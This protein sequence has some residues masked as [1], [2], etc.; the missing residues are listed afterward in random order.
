MRV[1]IVST[2]RTPIGRAYSGA[3]NAT[4]APTL[5]THVIQKVVRDTCLDPNDVEEVILGC[6]RPEGTQGGNLARVAAMRSGLP[7]SVSG[8]TVSR[9]CGSGLQA[10]VSAAHR[11]MAG[12]THLIVAGGL[13]SISLVQNEYTNVHANRDPWLLEHYKEVYMPMLETS[14]VLAERFGVS[15]QRQDEF[16]LE[17][18]RRTAAA[19]A[20][21]RF[22]KEIVPITTI[23]RIVDKATGD[24]REAEV[25][26]SQDEGNRP[27][28]SLEGLASLKPVRSGGS[29]T[30]GNSSQLSDGASACLVTSEEEAQKRGLTPLGFFT[31]YATAGCD[32]SVMGVGPV[33]A[34]PRLLDRMRLRVSDID[35]WELNEAFASQAVYC[36]EQL[37]IPLDLVNVDGGAISI[38]HPYG[39]SGARMMGHALIEGR[40]RG[41]RKVVVTMCL[42]GGMGA[43]ALFEVA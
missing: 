8:L 42:G 11:V 36:I 21:G 39:M 33:Y 27:N 19:Q 41:A 3:L 15:R 14:D 32:P 29:A 28:T 26:L 16:A 18:Q 5:A 2:A 34:V 30:A 10:I 25:T 6:A 1:A 40:R 12:E 24:V 9:Q 7:T 35:L 38:G 37:G 17:S 4:H 43:A 22:D 13:E 23:K 20:A 31:A